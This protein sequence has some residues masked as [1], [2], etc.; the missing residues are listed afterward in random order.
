MIDHRYDVKK[1]GKIRNRALI[2]LRAARGIKGRPI[3]LEIHCM[4][5]TKREIYFLLYICT[6]PL[7]LNRFFP[8]LSSSLP[9][10]VPSFLSN[11]ARS[12]KLAAHAAAKRKLKEGSRLS[13]T[14]SFSCLY[15]GSPLFLI[16]REARLPPREISGS[17]P[18]PFLHRTAA[19]LET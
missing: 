7:L 16:S 15:L 12:R 13:A 6:I 2:K 17:F 14:P 19:M 8:C 11:R 3:E 18:L 1:F 10:S 4:Q 5:I 9:C